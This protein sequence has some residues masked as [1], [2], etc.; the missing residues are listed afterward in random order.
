MHLATAAGVPTVAI[1]GPTPVYRAYP[2]RHPLSRVLRREMECSPC[3]RKSCPLK[4]HACMR[5]I[6]VEEVV[7]A[8]LSV[9]DNAR[10]AEAG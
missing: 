1:F 3:L 8:A 5:Q 6:D 4:H 9:T 7:E 10:L 2:W